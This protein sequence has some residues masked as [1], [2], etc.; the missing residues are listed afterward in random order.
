M[1]CETTVDGDYLVFRFTT[2]K[3]DK[4]HPVDHYSMVKN[5]MRIK[6]PDGVLHDDIHPDHLALIAMLSI[7]PFTVGKMIFPKP[8]SSKFF[9]STK[10]ISRYTCSPVD[11]SLEPW[12]PPEVSSPALAFSGGVDSSAALAV[13]PPDTKVIF[14]DRPPVQKSL[15]D[16]TAA[17]QSCAEVRSVGYDVHIIECDVEHIRNPVGFPTDL[18]NSIPA[19]LIAGHLGIDSISFGTVLESAFGLGHVRFRDYP[20]KS[21]WNLWSN[22]FSGAGISLCMPVSGV[23]EVGTRLI[24]DRAPIGFIAQ[25]CIRGTW[26][27]PCWNCW[28][29]FRKGLLG[30]SIGLKD[31]KDLNL[32][33]LFRIP[34]ARYHLLQ[35]PIKHENVIAYSC[36]KMAGG[37]SKYLDVLKHRILK[38]D[39]DY[40]FLEKWYSS[41][42]EL[43]PDRYREYVGQKLE[44]YLGRMDALEEKTVREWDMSALID[45]EEYSHGLERMEKIYFE[46]D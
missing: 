17:L 5:S 44:L 8:V 13:L 19:I 29:C 24:V 1:K 16:K 34:E 27:K 6:L 28:K 32:K 31:S 20:H 23:S 42:I 9:E 22:L 25:S 3:G 10:V 40:T 14:M 21:H 36:S 15:Y 12:K 26:Q 7:H 37:E 2:T 35:K 38:D 18:A 43:I 4:L 41:S 11:E 46:D 45:S 33:E 30:I 39:L